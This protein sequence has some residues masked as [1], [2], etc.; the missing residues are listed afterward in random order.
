LDKKQTFVN[1]AQ[2]N[3]AVSASN[4][5]SRTGKIA[6]FWDESFLWGLIAFDVFLQL[7][8]DFDLLTSS[9]IQTGALREYD[10]IFVPGGWVSNKIKA[11]GKE[12]Q[13]RI[14]DFVKRG[15]SY[16]GF[17]GGAG[18]ALEHKD[19]LSLV[20]VSRKPSKV[21][22]PSFSGKIKL[23]RGI[24]DHPIWKEV[25][26]DIAFHAWWPGQFAILNDD[27]VN[28][29][30]T[31]GAPEDGSYVADLKISPN[32]DWD[33][34]ER[35]YNTN[36]NP[37]RIKNEPAIL[38]STFGKGKVFL[39]YLHFETPEDTYGHKVLLNIFDYLTDGRV[40]PVS[41]SKD[42]EVNVYKTNPLKNSETTRR[43]AIIAGE[44]ERYAHDLISF[45]EHYSLWFWRN[46]WIIHWQR[47]VRGIEYCTIYSMFKRIASLSKIIEDIGEVDLYAKLVE[48]KELSIP[49]FD[50]AKHLLAL[51]HKALSSG[52]ISPLEITDENIRSLRE[53]LFSNSK[54]FGGY[55]KIIID[56][57]DEILLP[58][59]NLAKR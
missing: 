18:L 34:L 28:I 52:P 29:I 55:F 30:A 1:K 48:L 59:L 16:I 7:G 51:E 41:A 25:P 32:I 12:G 47:G 11:L 27:K 50:K 23:H 3:K 46:Q 40:R 8:L 43:C 2:K 45:G 4:R 6:L 31:Y 17:C 20:P 24:K 39:S 10:A 58:L 21:R 26:D 36:L 13:I 56:K 33:E 38:E 35:R 42:V 57:A 14:K 53:E 9:D 49:F 37:C 5:L 19:G 15:G 22:L 44:L 54:S